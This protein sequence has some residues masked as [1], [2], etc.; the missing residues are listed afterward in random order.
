M[1]AAAKAAPVFLSP[2]ELSARWNGAVAP[3]TLALWRTQ[4]SGPAY[5]K[6]GGKVFYALADV[7]AYEASQ[8]RGVK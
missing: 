6:L 3:S 7:E 4:K 2:A 8:R 1:S 5:T